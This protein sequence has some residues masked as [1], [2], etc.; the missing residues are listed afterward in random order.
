MS[1]FTFITCN[2]LGSLK[3]HVVSCAKRSKYRERDFI[4][5]YIPTNYHRVL[6]RDNKKRSG[7]VFSLSLLD[8]P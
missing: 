5:P 1:S 7:A 6:C 2:R 8:S 3:F 4:G